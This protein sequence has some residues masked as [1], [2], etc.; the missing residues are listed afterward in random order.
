[1]LGRKR[2]ISFRQLAGIGDLSHFV[3]SG[4]RENYTL[5]LDFKSE[6]LEENFGLVWGK[7]RR[8][9]Y[10]TGSFKGFSGKDFLTV[11]PPDTENL[12][13]VYSRIEIEE[14]SSGYL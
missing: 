6:T 8:N 12:Y 1:M 9:Q 14:V 11:R 13:R 10:R 7:L 5:G 2:Q 3:L 4:I